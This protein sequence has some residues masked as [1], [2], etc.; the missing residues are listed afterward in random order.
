MVLQFTIED[1]DLQVALTTGAEAAGMEVNEFA[2]TMLSYS[3]NTSQAMLG[4]QQAAT[5]LEG[6]LLQ[7][8]TEIQI[9]SYALR[10]QVT[11]LH[12]DLLGEHEQRAL[13]IAVEAN[14]LAS[15][16]ALN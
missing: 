7:K 15:E 1:L 13:D 9:N 8:L 10:H 3:F 16:A 6:T 11:N 5:F 4:V 2:K 12:A 14:E